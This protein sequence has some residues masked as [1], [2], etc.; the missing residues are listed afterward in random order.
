[1][2]R[3]MCSPMRTPDTFDLD[4]VRQVFGQRVNRG[5]DT[6]CWPWIAGMSHGYGKMVFR[7]R[8]IEAHR[9]AVILDGRSIPDGMFVDHTCMN[10]ACVNPAHLR[11]V[12]PATNTLENSNSA[13]A[14]NAAKT[15]CKRGHAFDEK[16]TGLYRNGQKV[17]RSCRTCSRE[18]MRAR[19]A[20]GK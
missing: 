20:A 7:G 19:R 17:G 11:V 6:D 16:N 10:R 18:R 12:D 9:I 8:Q 15:H 13:A 14:L 3:P 5:S 2:T 4:K 1:M